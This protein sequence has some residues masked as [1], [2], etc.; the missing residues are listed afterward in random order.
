M[1]LRILKLFLVCF[2]I[3]VVGCGSSSNS[4][5]DTPDPVISTGL[6]G[7]FLV[8]T[9]FA[10]E[11]EDRTILWQTR[12]VLRIEE[13]NRQQVNAEFI[14]NR[15]LPDR[16]CGDQLH[17]VSTDSSAPGLVSRPACLTLQN[18]SAG[19]LESWLAGR[20]VADP[21][22]TMVLKPSQNRTYLTNRERVTGTLFIKGCRQ[23]QF[24]PF[25][26]LVIPREALRLQTGKKE[27]ATQTL[28]GNRL[29]LMNIS[30][31][32]W[33]DLMNCTDGNH[34]G[35]YPG[36]D[37]FLSDL[38]VLTPRES[39]NNRVNSELAELAY[40]VEDLGRRNRLT[41][42]EVVE[43]LHQLRSGARGPGQKT[44][45][46]TQ[47]EEIRADLMG[48]FNGAL[49]EELAGIF[50]R[51]VKDTWETRQIFT[52]PLP[53]VCVTP[54][55]VCDSPPIHVDITAEYGPNSE[56]DGSMERPYPKIN[57]ALAAIGKSDSDCAP[58][59]MVAPGLYRE[60]LINPPSVRLRAK[61]WD[62]PV[63]LGRIQVEGSTSFEVTGLWIS[64]SWDGPALSIGRCA[65]ADLISSRVLGSSGYGIY[66]TGG[67][68][69]MVDS[70]ISG[71]RRNGDARTV[72]AGLYQ[73]AG[74]A[75]L[76]EV[77]F[78][79]NGGPAILSEGSDSRI[80]GSNVVVH[81]NS[82][83]WNGEMPERPVGLGAVEAGNGAKIVLRN[84]SLTDNEF[85]GLLA[86]EDGTIE[87]TGGYV[88]E[89]QMAE[90]DDHGGFGAY[91]LA[92]SVRL[93]D[94]TLSR[95]EFCG[96]AVAHEG[97]LDAQAGLVEH[98][99][100]GACVQV[101]GYRIDR[102]STEVIYRNNDINLDSMMPAMPEPEEF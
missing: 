27:G 66:Q 7:P 43:I 18:T 95:N 33:E 99:P 93:E 82:V 47:L 26:E 37:T 59:V 85:I 54:P 8:N 67:R 48:V 28:Q 74:S 20:Q 68:L 70:E 6:Q 41:N 22:L 1:F 52:R 12:W 23:G 64:G 19:D 2:T 96:M 30:Q 77:R 16:P 87:F 36:N 86:R 34:I 79:F 45:T 10:P 53:E 3:V 35:P 72:G 69:S 81:G 44:R 55:P 49:D 58:I 56:P 73:Q 50:D 98:H 11:G 15:G 97:D 80:G 17:V 31:Q 14:L 25:A 51:T 89:T 92:G 91:A 57:T 24:R 60:N 101:P 65:S 62:R 94:F 4:R 9:R 13:I 63:I 32:V 29:R 61:P 38:D 76:H 5:E 83:V 71:V 39:A 40:A 90:E 46:V 102:I 42:A 78:R 75:N 100:I 84:S 88:Q 21:S